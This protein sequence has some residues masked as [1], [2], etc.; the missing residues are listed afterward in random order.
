MLPVGVRLRYSIGVGRNILV[1]LLV[2]PLRHLWQANGCQC[3]RC[4]TDD[5]C[6][7][8]NLR[9]FFTFSVNKFRFLLFSRGFVVFPPLSA[10]SL[11][12]CLR[13]RYGFACCFVFF[14]GFANVSFRLRFFSKKN[15]FSSHSRSPCP[16]FFPLFFAVA[17]VVGASF[18]ISFSPLSFPLLCGSF[19]GWGVD[20]HLFQPS[21]VVLTMQRY[22]EYFFLPNYFSI[23]LF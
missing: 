22:K 7:F 4:Y 3:Q 23:F 8:H 19:S 21:W 16:F 13:F 11:C 14:I 6:A 18:V 20:C 1:H 17:L 5:C 9:P 10:A 15:S 12:L 2:E